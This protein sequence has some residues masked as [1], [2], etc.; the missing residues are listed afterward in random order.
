MPQLT[1]IVITDDLAQVHTYDPQSV[2]NNGLTSLIEVGQS[3][4]S[5]AEKLTLSLVP[6]K[7][8]AGFKNEIR[9]TVP[10]IVTDS[11]TGISSV[12]E[13]DTIVISMTSRP[14]STAVTRKTLRSIGIAILADPIVVAM[15]DDLKQVW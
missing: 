3:Q 5:L 11:T 2:N 6:I 8:D 14:H 4:R 1:P 9:I 12:L 15:I 7:G 13:T 10:H